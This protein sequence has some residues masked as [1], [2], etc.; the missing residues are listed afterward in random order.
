MIKQL[1]IASRALKKVRRAA[2]H[3]IEW[4]IRSLLAKMRDGGGTSA[5]FR[6][7]AAGLPVRCFAIGS[8]WNRHLRELDHATGSLRGAIEALLGARLCHDLLASAAHVAPSKLRIVSEDEIAAA[9]A[10]RAA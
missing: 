4:R 10:L 9:R 6:T 8:Q 2:A 5:E 3:N 1:S 7:L